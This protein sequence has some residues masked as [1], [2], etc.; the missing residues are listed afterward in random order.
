MIAVR[1]A[2]ACEASLARRP[3]LARA[4]SD[5]AANTR[6]AADAAL[7]FGYFGG[8]AGAEKPVVTPKPAQAAIDSA[9]AFEHEQL[10]TNELR[11]LLAN[12]LFRMV[13]EADGAK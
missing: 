1:P 5:R 9:F 7:G 6:P 13:L 12:D 11:I 8:L 4:E 3:S 2:A 10:N